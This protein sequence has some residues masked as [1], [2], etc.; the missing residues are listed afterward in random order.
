VATAIA[1]AVALLVVVLFVMPAEYGIDPTGAG[2]LT[3][4]SNLHSTPEPSPTNTTLPAASEILRYNITFPSQSR[5]LADETLALQEGDAQTMDVPVLD[6]NLLDVTA[7]LE[8]T[9]TA[10]GPPGDPDLFEATWQRADGSMDQPVLGRNAENGSGRFAAVAFVS[11]APKAETV[12]GADSLAATSAM[13]TRFPKDHSASGSWRLTIR[14]VDAPGVLGATPD[15]ENDV[16]VTVVARYYEPALGDAVSTGLVED[17]LSLVIDG[18]S[19][20]EFKLRMDEGSPLA[21]EWSANTTLTYDFHGDR[22]AD[23]NNFTSHDQGQAASKSGDFVA[24]FSGRHGWYWRNDS[25][26]SATVT[27][28]LTGKFAIIGVV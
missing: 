1:L 18:Q 4:I 19:R 5:I 28:H 3:G 13:K 21:F 11:S 25:S 14:L 7:R 27:V 9:D 10:L 20:I 15:S 17:T 22:A 24:P 2:K 6:G 12:D 23:A 8:W 26:Q 16:S